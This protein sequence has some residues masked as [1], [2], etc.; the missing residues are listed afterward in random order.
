MEQASNIV[1]PLPC[2]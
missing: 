1:T 2:S